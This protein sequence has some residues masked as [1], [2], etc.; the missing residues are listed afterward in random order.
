MDGMLSVILNV[1]ADLRL[2]YMLKSDA[3]TKGLTPLT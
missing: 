2:K 1:G 3:K